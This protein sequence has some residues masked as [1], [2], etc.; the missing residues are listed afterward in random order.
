[1]KALHLS[2]AAVAFAPIVDIAIAFKADSIRSILRLPQAEEHMMRDDEANPSLALGLYRSAYL[3]ALSSLSHIS[4]GRCSAR[5][6]PLIG[7]Q[8]QQTISTTLSGVIP[9]AI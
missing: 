4:S 2:L 3:L 6:L 8:L 1:M 9:T 7:F 5:P